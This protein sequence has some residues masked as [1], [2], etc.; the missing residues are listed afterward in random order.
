MMKRKMAQVCETLNK[1]NI[2]NARAL[3]KDRS[4]FVTTR[5]SVKNGRSRVMVG[6]YL[7][8]AREWLERD[9]SS[10]GWNSRY[11]K[12]T[13]QWCPFHVR[14]FREWHVWGTLKECALMVAAIAIQATTWINERLNE[15]NMAKSANKMCLALG[16]GILLDYESCRYTEGETAK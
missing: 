11:H 9:S 14:W 15:Y 8:E 12:Q 13:Y 4:V 10:V 2:A 3:D 7:A 16:D 5:Q 6:T 1:K